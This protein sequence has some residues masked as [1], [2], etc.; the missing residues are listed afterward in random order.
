MGV[1]KGVNV[2]LLLCLLLN[3]ITHIKGNG[4]INNMIS[5]TTLMAP[6]M[7]MNMGALMH[8]SGCASMSQTRDTGVQMNN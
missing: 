8:P 5:V 7:T 6:E 2:N 4:K 1:Y 3:L